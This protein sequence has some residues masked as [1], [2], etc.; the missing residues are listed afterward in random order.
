MIS[1]ED[2]MIVAVPKK[3]RLSEITIDYLKRIGL[4]F[5]KKDRHDVAFCTNMNIAI[6]FLPAAD[7]ALYVGEGRVDFGITGLDIVYESK[8][9][10]NVDIGIELGYGKCVLSLASPKSLNMKLSDYSGKN[11]VTSFPNLTEKFFKDNGIKDVNI[12]VVSGSVEVACAMGAAAGV[13]DLVET[14]DTIKEAGLEVTHEVFKTQ[15]VV[16]SKKNSPYKELINTLSAR[17]YGSVLSDKYALIEYNI[18]RKNLDKAVK[19]T[20]GLKSPT[21][22]PLEDENW[23]AIKSAIERGKSN[24]IMD[25]LYKV[26]ARAILVYDLQNCRI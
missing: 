15:A 8:E 10:R 23:V 4:K 21:I 18:E 3:G 24:E 20:P 16:I 9:D 26:G 7:I 2:K 12:R 14:G 5:R 1:V 17:L 11:V 19:V 22:M 13:V 25:E 6:I